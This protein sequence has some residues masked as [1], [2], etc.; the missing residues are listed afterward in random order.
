MSHS[1]ALILT[2]ALII[3]LGV[4]SPHGIKGLQDDERKSIERKKYTKVFL[5]SIYR[6]LLNTFFFSIK[7]SEKEQK[8]IRTHTHNNTERSE[9]KIVSF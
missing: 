3:K 9:V 7:Q 4:S 1:I 2:R 8:L 6:Q 5:F